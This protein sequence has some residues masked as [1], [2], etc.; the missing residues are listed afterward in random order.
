MH[1]EKHHFIF[2]RFGHVNW[3]VQRIETLAQLNLETPEMP[4]YG[5]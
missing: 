4:F 2:G 1:H 5:L 3:L